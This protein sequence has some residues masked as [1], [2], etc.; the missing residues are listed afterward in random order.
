[1]GV[2]VLVVVDVHVEVTVLVQVFPPGT[3][4]RAFNSAPFSAGK[5]LAKRPKARMA[6]ESFMLTKVLKR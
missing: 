3:G 2:G 1:V 4:S 5:A 6:T